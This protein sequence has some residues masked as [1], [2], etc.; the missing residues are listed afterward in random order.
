LALCATW[1]CFGQPATNSGPALQYQSVGPAQLLLSWPHPAPGFVLESTGQPA[2]EAAWAFW[3]QV[4]FLD[5]E[6][7]WVV[8][9]NTG[10]ARFFR[11]HSTQTGLTVPFAWNTYYEGV[12]AVKMTSSNIIAKAMQI[13]TN[14]LFQLSQVWQLDLGICAES[15]Y[16]R[17]TNGWLISNPTNF[18]DGI[19][20]TVAALHT[21]GFTVLGYQD[22]AFNHLDFEKDTWFWI[23]NGVD[24]MKLDMAAGGTTD[25]MRDYQGRRWIATWLAHTNRLCP[26]YTGGFDDMGLDTPSIFARWRN[27][28]DPTENDNGALGLWANTVWRLYKSTSHPEATGPGHFPDWSCQELTYPATNVARGCFSLASVATI[29]GDNIPPGQAADYPT[30]WNV[31]TNLEPWTVFGDR[32]CLP[33]R[34][35]LT[36]AEG[37]GCVWVKPLENGDMAVA[38]LN[39]TTNATATISVGW[40]NLGLVTGTR[41]LVRDCWWHT[42][43]FATNAFSVSVPAPPGL[44]APLFRL[45]T[46]I[47]TVAA[48]GRARRE[49]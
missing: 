7:H 40:T 9:T 30:Q 16:G 32:L 1:T 10:G 31:V 8:V 36:N 37:T 23:T 43:S 20:D 2:D 19:K 13:K 14:G 11:L 27:C 29:A 34:P 46:N 22:T 21:N 24:G 33:G 41:V 17:D 42:N 39:L 26:L 15:N 18:P 38:L 49:Q 4:P 28:A 5:R 45:S 47:T 25:A 44:P 6:Q 12:L 48:G 35:V 3:P